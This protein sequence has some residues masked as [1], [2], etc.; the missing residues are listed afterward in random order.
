[1]DHGPKIYGSIKTKGEQQCKA[2]Q[3][4]FFVEKND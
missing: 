2:T 4:L 1:M 3:K